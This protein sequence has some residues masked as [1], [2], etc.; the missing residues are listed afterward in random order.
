[1]MQINNL[2]VQKR[3]KRDDKPDYL[4]QLFNSFTKK[5]QTQSDETSSAHAEYTTN[6][7][8]GDKRKEYETVTFS[9]RV[10]TH[11]SNKEIDTIAKKPFAQT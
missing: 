9:N 3:G 10:T 5:L 6:Q 1:M 4:L 11:R 7:S 2:L 8:G